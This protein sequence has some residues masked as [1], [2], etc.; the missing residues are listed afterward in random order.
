MTRYKDA[1]DSPRTAIRFNCELTIPSP[2]LGP[3]HVAESHTSWTR[4]HENAHACRGFSSLHYNDDTHGRKEWLELK[5]E[6]KALQRRQITQLKA[7][8]YTGESHMTYTF[9]NACTGAN[10]IAHFFGRQ[11]RQFSSSHL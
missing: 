4:P 6:Y 5:H 11:R 10:L 1:K 9:D 3:V 2:G 8:V 7:S